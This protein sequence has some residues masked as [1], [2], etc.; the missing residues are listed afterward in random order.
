MTDSSLLNEKVNESWQVKC[1]LL[2]YNTNIILLY[3]VFFF[4]DAVVQMVM[5]RVNVTLVTQEMELTAQVS[6][7]AQGCD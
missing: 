1:F 3:F 2:I 4:S 5:G 6:F 7:F